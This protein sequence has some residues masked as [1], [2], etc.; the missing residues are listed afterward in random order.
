MDDI[1]HDGAADR[2]RGAGPEIGIAVEQLDIACEARGDIEQQPVAG[3][4]IVMPPAHAFEDRVAVEARRQ[5]AGQSA[6]RAEE[7]CAGIAGAGAALMAVG[8]GDDADAV[9]VAEGILNDP[10]EG[11]PGGVHLDGGL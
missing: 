2:F 10:F 7:T 1:A 4:R 3:R 11:A 6:H 8:V 9:A 5:E